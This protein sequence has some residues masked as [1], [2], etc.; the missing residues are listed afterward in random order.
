[1]C[2]TGTAAARWAAMPR[3]FFHLHAPGAVLKDEEGV[4][5]PDG[6]AAWYQAVRSARDLIHADLHMGAVWTGQRIEIADAAGTAVDHIPLADIARYA[7]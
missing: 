3:F 6:E 1:L 7:L 2:G 5:L 4:I